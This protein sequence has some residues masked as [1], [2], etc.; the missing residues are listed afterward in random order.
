[1]VPTPTGYNRAMAPTAR[2]STSRGCESKLDRDWPVVQGDPRLQERAVSLSELQAERAQ[3]ESRLASLDRTFEELVEESHA[4]TPDDEHD[5]EGTTA[6]DRAQVSAIRAASHRRLQQV[7]T[8]MAN[9]D[10]ETFGTCSRCGAPIGRERLA[11]LPGVD[12]C[13]TCASIG[14]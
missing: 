6:Y 2:H 4:A 10:A 12:H 14:A 9:I 11:A 8:A 1:M 5:P 7:E 3:I 13:V